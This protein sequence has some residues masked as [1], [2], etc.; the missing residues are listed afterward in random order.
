MQVVIFAGGFGTRISEDTHL[1]PKP[2]V[3]I[4]SQP[5][6]WHIMKTYAHWGHRD[7]L[8]LSGYKSATIKNYFIN[9]SNINSDFKINTKTGAVDYL[10]RPQEDWN[11]TVMYT[12]LE[13]QTGG[14]LKS[15]AEFLDEKFLLTYGDGLS[16]VRINDTIYD[17]NHNKAEITVTAV[18]PESRY[19]AVEIESNKVLKFREKPAG[20]QGWINAGFM[21]CNKT[22]LD[23][24]DGSN[25]AFE[26]SAIESCVA[27]GSL[28]A[29]KH[30]GFW[31]PMDTK[32]DH[33]KLNELWE[34]NN[35]SWK[36]WE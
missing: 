33:M 24:I 22:V 27:K 17:H 29:F 1:I 3:Q 31:Q 13:T 11:V 18:R 6:L 10:N 35:A 12:G 26:S 36:V 28:F 14:R 16:D 2:M 15:V 8:I 20:E 34:S 9:F 19:G 23:Y 4:G 25:D 7:F 5:I 32:R 21:V 30:Y